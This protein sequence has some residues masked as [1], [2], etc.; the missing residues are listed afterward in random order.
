MII[1]NIIPIVTH[2]SQMFDNINLLDISI[3]IM[4]KWILLKIKIKKKYS[5]IVYQKYD[6]L[7][8]KIYIKAYCDITTIF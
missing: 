5:T 1:I 2:I 4:L 3:Y 7:T 8:D 6:I